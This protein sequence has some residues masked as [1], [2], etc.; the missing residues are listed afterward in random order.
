MTMLTPEIAADVVAQ[1]E[2]AAGEIGQALTRAFD[3]PM[4]A[5]VGEPC[6]LVDAVEKLESPG[7]AVTLHFGPSA[8]AILIPQAGGLLPPGYDSTDPRAQSKLTTLAQELSMLV[9]PESLLAEDAQGF[10]VK[11]LA[12]ALHE[13]GASKNASL[14]PL[15]LTSG[16]KQGEALVIWPLPG[17]RNIIK[18][19]DSPGASA[20]LSQPDRPSDAVGK[21]AAN[22]AGENKSAIDTGDATSTIDTGG[23][24]VPAAEAVVYTSAKMRSAED[25]SDVPQK[26]AARGPSLRDLP[27]Y[28]RSLLKIRVPLSVTLAEKK[29]PLGQILE[30]G[31]GSILQFEKS[32][33]EMLDLNVSNL[34]IARGE[35]VKVGDKFGLR[36]TSLIL[37]SER[38]KAVQ[39]ALPGSIST[40]D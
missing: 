3:I 14:F 4:A 37:P 31:P 8:I 34:P 38:F 40:K 19:H 35:A 15:L 32:C 2:V 29:Q 24:D 5:T 9:L 28:S 22:G 17:A 11:H 16:A 1:C 7:V 21:V 20:S 30:I 36:V 25:K 26:S 39:P 27:P 13:G 6:R 23:A 10:C 33:E 12:E 18:L